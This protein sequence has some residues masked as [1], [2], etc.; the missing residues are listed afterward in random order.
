MVLCALLLFPTLNLKIIAPFMV[1]FIMHLER[2][3]NIYG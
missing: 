1:R 2:S 3:V